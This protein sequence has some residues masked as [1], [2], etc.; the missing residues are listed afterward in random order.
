[1]HLPSQL[2]ALLYVGLV[3]WLFRR[4]A[5]ERPNVT[6]ALWIPCLWLGI[7]GSRFVSQW[8]AIFGLHLGGVSVEE[9]SPLDALVF[10]G[11][12]G[13]GLYVL[14]QRRVNLAEFVRHNQWVAIYLAY[15]LVAILWSDFPF[16]AFKRW[17]KLFGQPVMVL[18]VLTEPDPL[19]AVTRLLKRVGYAWILISILFIKYFPDLG[20][21]FSSW[22]GQPENHGICVDGKNALGFDCML[23]GVFFF[24]QFLRTWPRER[25]KERRNELILCATFFAAD[26][27]LLHMSQSSTSLVC[28]LVAM[29]VIFFTGVRFVNV[30]RFGFYLLAL[31][32]LAAAADALFGLHDLVIKELGKDPTLTGRTDVWHV[33]LHQ[34]INPV[35]GAGFESF[36]LG[37]RVDK[38]NAQFIGTVFNEAHNGYLETYLNLGCL[39]LALTFALVAATFVKS[40]RALVH[41]FDFGRFRLAYL[42]AFLIYNWTEAA[43]RTHTPPFF[44]FFLAGIEY[45]K[46]Q[47][48]GAEQAVGVAGSENELGP[49]M[50]EA[51]VNLESDGEHQL[52]GA[53]SPTRQLE[54]AAGPLANDESV[55]PSLAPDNRDNGQPPESHFV[56]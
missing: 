52:P 37:E 1:M 17:T 4:D 23:M 16:V 46:L 22:T 54:I 8:L 3:L 48:A 51:S 50:P 18:I 30:R 5:R 40:C 27:W 25:S 13:S 7:S 39:G 35:L 20:R 15:C 21:G 33:L 38:I 36:W 56:T 9:G 55:V 53:A 6:G 32:V 34:D 26:F 19:E 49:A 12:I 31:A 10:F 24:W 2:A 45:P 11:L 29:T 14:N 44:I 28:L 41:D 47:L 42:V 43:F